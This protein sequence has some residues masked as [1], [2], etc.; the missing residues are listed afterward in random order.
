MHRCFFK[1]TLAVL[2]AVALLGAS[3]AE[4]DA[5]LFGWGW[6]SRGCCPTTATFYAPR[7]AYYVPTAYTGSTYC[8]TI[9]QPVR[10]F[11]QPV[12]NPCGNVCSPC[13]TSC[14]SGGCGVSY[15]VIT[16]DECYAPP[17]TTSPETLTTPADSTPRTFAPDEQG[18]SADEP[19][20]ADSGF[21]A[22]E[23]DEGPAEPDNGGAFEGRDTETFKPPTTIPQRE[24]APTTLPGEQPDSSTG[25]EPADGS[26]SD[27]NSDVEL[28]VPAL[29]K[30]D[31]K[32]T[33][34]AAVKRTRSSIRANFANPKVA[35]QR[36]EHNRGW[37][38][39]SSGTRVVKK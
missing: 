34:R 21:R 6:H 30:F 33:W 37:V 36:I 17:T 16:S 3:V 2:S 23:T 4:T 19:Y 5:C 8:P 35:R 18:E 13:G 26:S 27:N 25:D 7:A 15:R 22:R 29:Q 38:P 14:P 31:A 32:I 39:V 12:Y 11:F 24:P 20:D 10:T 1:Y 28:R 9:S